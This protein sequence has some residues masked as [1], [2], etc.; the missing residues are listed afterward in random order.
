MAK[1]KTC[2]HN[3]QINNSDILKTKVKWK[4]TMSNTVDNNV[5]HTSTNNKR[6]MDESQSL[7]IIT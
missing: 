3:F 4:T 2:I 1:L 7:L 5:M 6:S